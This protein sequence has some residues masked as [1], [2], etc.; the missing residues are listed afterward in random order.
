L[1]Y[2]SSESQ[3]LHAYADALEIGRVVGV[4]GVVLILPIVDAHGQP[5][6]VV[7]IDRIRMQDAKL[8]AVARLRVDAAGAIDAAALGAAV[9]DLRA[10]DRRDHTGPTPVLIEDS[11]TVALAVIEEPARPPST[12]IGPAHAAR[13]APAAVA[14]DAHTTDATPAVAASTEA[15]AH[16]NLNDASRHAPP[17][18]LGL[19][20]GI[21]GGVASLVSWGLFVRQYGL[22][23]GYS[24]QKGNGEDYRATLS[25]LNSTEFAPLIMGVAGSLVLT[26]SLPWL[27]PD[28]PPRS[29]PALAIA[30]GGVGG[31]LAIAGA[32]YTIHG[33]QCDQFDVEGR[34]RELLT[35]THFGPLL[36]AGSLPWL[37]VPLVYLLRRGGEARDTSSVSLLPAP[38]GNGASLLWRGHL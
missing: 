29:V 20:L 23:L 11:Q 38:G 7:Q 4:G 10:G 19:V 30:A 15:G 17:T 5:T 28:A 12:A 25:D 34:C 32:I 36:L 1:R 16:A 8:M 6:D 24:Q 27:L 18:P 9:H 3:R 33:A 22:E 26:V 31:V 21:T 37:S 2:D 14:D 13:L 35:T